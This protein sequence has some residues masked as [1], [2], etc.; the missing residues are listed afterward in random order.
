[1]TPRRWL[2]VGGALTALVGVAFSALAAPQQPHSTWDSS[3]DLET[4]S[5]PFALAQVFYPEPV[6]V[7]VVYR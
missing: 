3:A 5:Q 4:A 7:P 1:V 2:A 6:F